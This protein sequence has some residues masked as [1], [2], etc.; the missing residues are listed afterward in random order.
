V[1]LHL[2]CLLISLDFPVVTATPKVS[3]GGSAE[4]K[5]GQESI[6]ENMD[7][8]KADG[9]RDSVLD[10]NEEVEENPDSSIGDDDESAGEG[11][12]PAVLYSDNNKEG[13][14]GEDLKAVFKS[15]AP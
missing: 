6:K 4:Q 5:D 10:A 8:C 13:G 9:E 12:K 3:A 7:V 2:T 11:K 1:S 14:M 15:M